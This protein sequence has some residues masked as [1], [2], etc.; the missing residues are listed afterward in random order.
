MLKNFVKQIRDPPVVVHFMMDLLDRNCGNA[1]NITLERLGLRCHGH[2][3][4]VDTSRVV[5]GAV[6]DERRLLSNG[7]L[8]TSIRVVVITD[9]RQT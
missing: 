4:R 3:T 2:V 6:C 8:W 9:C 1:N 7:E 5:P